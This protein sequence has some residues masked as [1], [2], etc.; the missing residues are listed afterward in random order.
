MKLET[1]QTFGNAT[2][3]L[4]DREIAAMITEVGADPASG[5]PLQQIDL[6]KVA[7]NP[8]EETGE[9]RDALAVLARPDRTIEL[10]GWPNGGEWVR[11]YGS[12][13]FDHLVAHSGNDETGANMIIWPVTAGM[14]K[15]VIT[16][17]LA[18][19]SPA[20]VE[21]PDLTLE[22]AELLGLASV[23]DVQQEILWRAMADREDAPH[24][25]IDA[26]K[27]Q[28]C[29]AK[30]REGD[31]PRWMV[32]RL[33]WGLG[34]GLPGKLSDVDDILT[35]LCNTR[36]L[37]EDVG[38]LSPL[39]S[40]DLLFRQLADVEGLSAVSV[41]DHSTGRVTRRVYQAN[42]AQIW[43]YALDGDL[44]LSD[45]VHLSVITGEALSSELALLV[46]N[47][48]AKAP[49]VAAKPVSATCPSCG[50]AVQDGQSF[51]ASCGASLAAPPPPPKVPENCGQ[52]GAKLEPGLRFCTQCGHPV[53]T[54]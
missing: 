38:G 22:F 7:R 34:S 17:P 15:S 45:K 18:G 27:L 32:S 26:E 42:R 37:I 13:A 43:R 2:Y 50:K 31:D 20:P 10:R 49:D 4:A 8:P 33:M 5:S 28:S 35:R 3:L 44:A 25:L 51:C 36:L 48:A 29:Y 6:S 9:L 12:D 46:P 14:V 21:G 54:A 19:M 47:A 30:G 53:E 24:V 39:P 23:V 16:A 1:S 52:C 41:T 11:Y 40:S